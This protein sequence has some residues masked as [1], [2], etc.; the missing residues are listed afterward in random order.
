M[1]MFM[2]NIWPR[3]TLPPIMLGSITSAIGITVIAYAV[4][5]ERTA[6][7]YGMMALTGHG[8][9]MRLNP[10]S[11]HGLAYFPTMTAPITFLVTFAFP[12]GGSVALTLMSTVFNNKSGANHTNAKQGIHFAF[13][14]M[15]PFMWLMVLLSTALGNVWI[16]KEGDHEVVNG[17]YLLSLI[18]G[19]KLVRERKSRG[20]H[21]LDKFVA[22]EGNGDKEEKAADAL[23]S[24]AV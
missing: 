3:Q 6:L 16:R 7:L 13:I 5:T 18:T 22:K 19:K 17:I 15:I 10:G 20:D 9:G 23:T 11:L 4:N 1:A 8:V 24:T 12:F 2:C 14:S 21:D